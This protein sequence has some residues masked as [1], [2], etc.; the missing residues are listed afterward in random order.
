MLEASWARADAVKLV[1]AATTDKYECILMVVCN[2]VD[3]KCNVYY[4]GTSLHL[5]Y[6]LST[7]RASISWAVYLQT[8]T[9]CPATWR[10]TAWLALPG[11]ARPAKS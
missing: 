11:N 1:R 4:S 10:L 6:L 8:V 9:T 5:I 3:R 2:P 7:L